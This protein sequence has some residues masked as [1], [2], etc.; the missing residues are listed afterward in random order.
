MRRRER[1][2]F[3]V[4]AVVLAVVAVATVFGFTKDIP[5]V[6]EPYEIKA[7]FRD[8][9][10]MKPDA[11]VR[12]GGVEVGKVRKVEHER[13]GSRQ[14]VV[15]MSIKDPGRPIHTDARAMIRP[16]IFLEGNFFVDLEPGTPSAPEMEDGAT[17]PVTRTSNPVQLDEV[18]SILRRDVRADLK[19][20][21]GELA[22]TRDAGGA[23]AFNASLADQPG[24]FR[25]SSVV[26]EALI[27]ERPGDLS[28][29]VRDTGVVA[30]AV[31]RSPERLRTLVTD[32]NRTFAALAN[33]E[34]DLR[35]S[36]RELPATLREA[37]PALADL[38]D[39]FPEVRAFAAAARPGVRSTGPTARALTPLV[40]ELR[41]LVSENELRGL[42]RDLRAATPAT[43]ALS[44]DTVP[45]LEQVRALASCT[46]N[47]LVPFDNLKVPDKAHPASGP[48]HQEA[49]KF[50][51]GLAGESR[52]FDSNGQ[53]FKVLGQGGAET[54]DLGNGLFGTALEPIQGVNPPPD[55]TMPPFRPD[56]P[57]ETQELPNLETK[58]GL[59]PRSVNTRRHA[60]RIAKR[61]REARALAMA[62]T[63]LQLL[64]SGDRK[65]RVLDKDATAALL[66][67]LKE[68][69]G[70]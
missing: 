59:P 5:F 7:A 41:G 21:F 8:T 20:T 38:N 16:R 45:L 9:S 6:N 70:R 50:L 67:R 46:T 48:I 25:W 18:L 1:S 56:T 36:I 53:W 47:V 39:A 14:A 34:G 33:S 40:R 27:G 60:D 10:G 51:P 22:E 55:R 57:C 69:K 66:E 49:G 24:A 61:S 32:F 31:D 68:G 19:S 37:M 44:R 13:P 4:G 11:P 23:E 52:S 63:Q 17:I 62:M 35:A 30:G 43:A 58:P 26:A 29:L 12:I 3:L 42:A 28:R 54:L 15:T 64:A 2:P 65:T